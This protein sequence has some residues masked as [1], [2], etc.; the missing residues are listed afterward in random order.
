M[1]DPNML[2]TVQNAVASLST[3]VAEAQ[4][5]VRKHHGVSAVSQRD[6]QRAFTLLNFFIRDHRKRSDFATM[7]ADA[8]AQRCM[9]LSL[10]V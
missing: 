4:S 2:D 6:I 5:F 7:P 8:L 1:L 3:M 9:F 10:G